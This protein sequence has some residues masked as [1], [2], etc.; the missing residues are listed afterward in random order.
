[1]NGQILKILEGPW[2]S[3]CL[4]LSEKW[5]NLITYYLWSFQTSQE[6]RLSIS[7]FF[8]QYD[9][10]VGF[11]KMPINIKT[12]KTIYN[13]SIATSSSF[14]ILQ[15]NV[16]GLILF[17]ISHWANQLVSSTM[18]CISV[19]KK[20]FQT[21]S[22]HTVQQC[23]MRDHT[24][25]KLSLVKWEISLHFA[26]QTYLTS[27]PILCWCFHVVHHYHYYSITITNHMGSLSHQLCI[28]TL[29]INAVTSKTKLTNIFIT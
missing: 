21:H 14:L 8:E 7:W 13:L 24:N 1:M 12:A 28:I 29:I 18:S 3:F 20:C 5:I 17:R 2:N 23:W 22:Q 15:W 4:L 25:H 10:S 11:C 27:L 6:I 19:Y 26:T 16:K 9:L